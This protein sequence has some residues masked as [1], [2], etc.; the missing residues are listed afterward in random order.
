MI[1][2]L[3]INGKD[4]VETAIERIKTFEPQEGYWL[5]YSGGKDSIVVKALCDI[6]NVKYE[7]HYSHTSVD[8]P[9]VVS[10]IKNQ[11][12][13]EIDYPIDKEGNRITMWNLIPKK[14]MPPTR[15]V[16]YCCEALKERGGG[17]KIQD[18]WCKESGIQ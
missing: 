3:N 4:K 10:F 8:P 12:D 1:H 2:Q 11:A 7:A 16:R 17:R 5:A 9:E 18:N 6:A 14:K 15:L 13:V